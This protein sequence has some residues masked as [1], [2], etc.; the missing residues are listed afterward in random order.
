MRKNVISPRYDDSFGWV[1]CCACLNYRFGTILRYGGHFRVLFSTE[2]PLI[3]YLSSRAS[4]CPYYGLIDVAVNW[5]C[6]P[7]LEY[8]FAGR[9]VCS[10]W[11][12]LLSMWWLCSVSLNVCTAFMKSAEPP[13]GQWLPSAVR[14]RPAIAVSYMLEP[15]NNILYFS[16]ILLWRHLCLFPT[17]HARHVQPFYPRIVSLPFN[18]EFLFVL[19]LRLQAPRQDFVLIIYCFYS[20]LSDVAFLLSTRSTK[21]TFA[22]SLV[23]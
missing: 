19:R 3:K 7:S 4:P 2:M 12:A 16:C 20:F 9:Q 15:I 13:A 11:C 1:L 22:S 5:L 17:V 10:F 23:K 14:A 8:R 18:V 21:V 6:S